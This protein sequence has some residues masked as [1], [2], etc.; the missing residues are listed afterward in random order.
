MTTSVSAEHSGEAL[1]VADFYPELGEYLAAA[2]GT[3]YDADAA[4][5]R[6][7]AWLTSHAVDGPPVTEPVRDYLAQF[8]QVPKLTTGQE[9]ELAV[10]IEAGRRADLER[11]AEDGRRPGTS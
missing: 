9:T 2:H 8:S 11:L 1:F 10:R 4:R 6:F 7:L 3:G 5:A